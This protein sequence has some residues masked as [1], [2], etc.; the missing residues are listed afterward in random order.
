[1]CKKSRIHAFN[2]WTHHCGSDHLQT[3]QEHEKSHWAVV[4]SLAL[5]QSGF[6]SLSLPG[7]CRVLGVAGVLS[8]AGSLAVSNRIASATLFWADS[9]N[10]SAL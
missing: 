7:P 2:S 6:Q 4:R 1:M 5:H 10:R 3:T 9:R 8:R